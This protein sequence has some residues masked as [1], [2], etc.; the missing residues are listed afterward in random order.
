MEASLSLVDSIESRLRIGGKI[1]STV[2]IEEAQAHL[3]ELI[4]HL[5]PGEE[6]V[7]TQGGYSACPSQKN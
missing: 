4:G 1:M 5:K 7:I 2:S 3:A 6:V